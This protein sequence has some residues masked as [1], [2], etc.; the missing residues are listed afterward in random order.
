MLKSFIY[1]RDTQIGHKLLNILFRSAHNLLST[2][3]P[4]SLVSDIAVPFDSGQTC[5]KARFLYRQIQKQHPK[6]LFLYLSGYPESNWGHT[7]P[8]RV[9][10]HYAIPRKFEVFQIFV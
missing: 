3:D 5:L 1:S 10:Y 4:V 6:V 8:K 2:F 9:H 7:L